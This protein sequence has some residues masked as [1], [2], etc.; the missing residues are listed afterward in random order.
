[1]SL[2]IETI[3]NS[4]KIT[5]P[6]GNYISLNNARFTWWFLDND[7]IL[8]AG[9][10]TF[11]AGIGTITINGGTPISEND[12]NAELGAAFPASTDTPSLNDVLLTGN[13]AGNTRIINMGN[14]RL[15]NAGG[16]KDAVN[17]EFLLAQGELIQG[18]FADNAAAIAGGIFNNQLYWTDNAGERDIKI[19]HE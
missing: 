7:L 15:P 14:P 17:M 9:A 6:E 5:P 4:V 3:G 2:I 13:N 18:P 11:R 1:M 8:I 19:C 12:V 10:S 16:T